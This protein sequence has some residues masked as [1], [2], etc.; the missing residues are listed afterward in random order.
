MNCSQQCTGHCRDGTT[1]NHVTGQ[2]D[3]G[4]AD[5]WYSNCSQ[6][7]SE[8]CREKD[9]CNYKTGQCDMGCALGWT[10]YLCDKGRIEILLNISVIVLKIWSNKFKTY[11]SLAIYFASIF[12]VY[13]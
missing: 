4:C 10:G 3:R 6:K 11:V 5:G 12:I 1:C 2:C 8:H 9:T 13:H 7:C